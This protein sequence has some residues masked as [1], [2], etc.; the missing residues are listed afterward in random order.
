MTIRETLKP[1]WR[2]ID[3]PPPTFRAGGA[4]G[5]AS[6][7]TGFDGSGNFSS[8]SRGAIPRGG[9]GSQRVDNGATIRLWR[10]TGIAGSVGGAVGATTFVVDANALDG[11]VT[12]RGGGGG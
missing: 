9:A 3:R 2:A 8:G 7:A 4:I 5:G 6:V 11:R 1:S 10:S 12:G